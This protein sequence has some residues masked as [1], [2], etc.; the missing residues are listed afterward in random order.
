MLKRITPK[1]VQPLISGLKKINHKKFYTY[2]MVTNTPE[3]VDISDCDIVDELI[4]EQGNLVK[5]LFKK[6]KI[7]EQYK[8]IK[9]QLSLIFILICL[10]GVMMI[11]LI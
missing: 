10:I 11:V 3:K 8:G 5:K 2:I 1:E 6:R 9:T 4:I 7:E